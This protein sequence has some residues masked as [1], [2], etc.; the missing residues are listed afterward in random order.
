MAGPGLHTRE[1]AKACTPPLLLLPLRSQAFYPDQSWV[2]MQVIWYLQASMSLPEKCGC[3]LCPA[4][5]TAWW[6]M[7]SLY[8]GRCPG[9][10]VSVL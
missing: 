8:P 6:G 5:K 9:K 10:V 4:D 3:K 2:C 7:G 1:P